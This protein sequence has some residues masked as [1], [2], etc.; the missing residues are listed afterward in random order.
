M[1]V[2]PRRA[3]G[4]LHL[5]LKPKAVWEATMAV[6]GFADGETFIHEVLT[7]VEAPAERFGIA[8]EPEEA[9]APQKAPGARLAAAPLYAAPGA[10]PSRASAAPV[11]VPRGP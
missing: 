11:G 6:F 7:S 5:Y 1:P 8:S 4:K 10:V 2:M 3:S 9:P